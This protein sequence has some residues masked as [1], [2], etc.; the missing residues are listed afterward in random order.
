MKNKVVKISP[1]EEYKQA[2]EKAKSVYKATMERAKLYLKFREGN[3]AEAAKII[4]NLLKNPKRAHWAESFWGLSEQRRRIEIAAGHLQKYISVKYYIQEGHYLSLSSFRPTNKH[5][6]IIFK[7]WPKLEVRHK[8]D[9]SSSPS[10]ETVMNI[11][12]S[13]FPNIK[14]VVNLKES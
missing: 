10:D 4:D 7:I 11:S 6:N 2:A 14:N 8:V 9:F 1:A 5:Y 3:G 12:K 13:Y